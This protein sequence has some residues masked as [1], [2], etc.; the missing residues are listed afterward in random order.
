MVTIPLNSNTY[1]ELKL[2]THN[3][4]EQNNVSVYNVASGIVKGNGILLFEVN[5][6]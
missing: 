3:I 2:L 4:E 1:I 6:K 5:D